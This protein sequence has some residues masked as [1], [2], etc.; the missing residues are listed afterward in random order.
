VANLWPLKFYIP[1]MAA[2]VVA[3]LA[4]LVGGS[5][6]LWAIWH[7]GWRSRRLIASRNA[8]LRTTSRRSSSSVPQPRR[9]LTCGR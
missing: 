9:W 6:M 3:L 7:Y 2:V 4:L 5:K 1:L 8:R